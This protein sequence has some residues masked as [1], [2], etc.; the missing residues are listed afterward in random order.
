VLKRCQKT[1]RA[2]DYQLEAGL[3]AFNPLSPP[4]RLPLMR[5]VWSRRWLFRRGEALR[6]LDRERDERTKAAPAEPRGQ[7]PEPLADRRP[8]GLAR[9]RRDSRVV[10]H[11]YYPAFALA[12]ARSP[13]EDA[14]L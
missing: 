4:A 8:A 2:N 13:L 12:F 1:D 5:A 14:L 9:R 6:H 10:T 7:Q 11:H 3:H